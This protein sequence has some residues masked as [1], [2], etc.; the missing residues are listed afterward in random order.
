M[1]AAVLE[2]F[3]LDIREIVTEPENEN[4]DLDPRAETTTVITP[5][6]H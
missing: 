6:C 1:P 3:D 2:D 5:L 4:G